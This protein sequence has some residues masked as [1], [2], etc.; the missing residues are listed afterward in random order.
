[1]VQADRARAAEAAQ[2]AQAEKARDRTRQALDAMTSAV[3]GDSLTT[4]K[5]IS[6]EQK[7][8]LTEVLTYYREFAGEKADDE[9]SRDRTADAALRVGLIEY[10]LGRREEAAAAVRLANDGFAKLAADAP[11]VPKYRRALA[12]S[13]NNLGLL[14]AGLGKRAEAEPQYR[15][16]LALYEKLADDAPAVPD[17][18]AALA[19]SH[20]NLGLLWADLGKKPKAEQH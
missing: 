7:K 16:A 12:S 8:F 17:Y 10:R 14:L 1:M 18:R 9:P 2:R 5:E 19:F 13:H 4:Q 11:A 15:Q 3:T 20:T 6:D